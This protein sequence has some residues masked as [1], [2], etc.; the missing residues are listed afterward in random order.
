MRKDGYYRVKLKP[1]IAQKFG[2]TTE[3]IVA[4]WENDYGYEGSWLFDYLMFRD[5]DLALIGDV[6]LVPGKEKQ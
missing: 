5:C 1:L 2:L 4:R 6:R 3:L